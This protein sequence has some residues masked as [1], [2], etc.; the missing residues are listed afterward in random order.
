[1]K[2]IQRQRCNQEVGLRSVS[3]SLLA[4][5]HIIQLHHLLIS[6]AGAMTPHMMHADGKKTAKFCRAGG[7]AR[8]HQGRGAEVDFGEL[9]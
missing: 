1:M 3:A 7:G 5:K 9:S 2:Y 6:R 4:Y 8:G